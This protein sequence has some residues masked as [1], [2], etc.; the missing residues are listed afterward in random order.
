[1]YNKQLKVRVSEY[2]LIKLDTIIDKKY[3]GHMT[4]SELVR[5]LINIEY[6]KLGLNHLPKYDKRYKKIKLIY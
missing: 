1:M 3:N 2:E 6:S 4:R 5:A